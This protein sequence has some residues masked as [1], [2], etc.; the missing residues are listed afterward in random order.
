ME[1]I[2]KPMSEADAK[3]IRTWRYEDPYAT[4]SFSTDD[5]G[6]LAEMLDPRSPYYSVRD[7]QENIIGFVNFGTSALVWHSEV[8]SIYIDEQTVAIGLGMRPDL[9][10]KGLGQA[11]VDAGLAFAREHFHPQQFLL[12]VYSWNARA[13]RVYERAGFKTVRTIT[14]Q[15]IHGEREF[16]EMRRPA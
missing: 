4:Y 8:P 5:P 13:I 11:F 12:L 16:I 14:I 2:F 1:F 9:T 6:G 15:N 7:E 10:G 3:I